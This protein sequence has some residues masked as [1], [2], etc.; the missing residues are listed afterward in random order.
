MPSENG[1]EIPWNS[2]NR[3]VCLLGHLVITS[4]LSNCFEHFVQQRARAED[5]CPFS[6]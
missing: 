5:N 6:C 4:N 3:E 1:F 2:F